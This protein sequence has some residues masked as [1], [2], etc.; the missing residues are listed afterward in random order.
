MKR[1]VGQRLYDAAKSA[2]R[3]AFKTIIW[4][5]KLMLPITLLV[6]GLNYIGAIGWLSVQLA[7]LF[8][9]IGLSGEAVIVFLTAILLNI[10]AAIAVIATLGF[11]FRAVTILAV[12]CLIAHNLIIETAIQKK[13][14]LLRP[15]WWFYVW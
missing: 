1:S 2:V 13:R 12:M 9:F 10:Y 15:M 14:G 4:I 7:P 11:D 3:P 5:L 8:R 6:A